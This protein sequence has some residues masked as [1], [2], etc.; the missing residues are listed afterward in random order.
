MVIAT[1]MDFTCPYCRSLVPV[2]DSVLSAFPADVAVDF[3]HFPLDSHEFAVPG[4]VA[5]ECA[6]R[7]GRFGHMYH[8]LY[9]QMESIGMKQWREFAADAGIPDVAAF[10]RCI[11]LPV[12]SFLRIGAGRAL[13]ES[14]G[15]VGTPTIWVN[16][17]QHSG[18]SVEA[19]R[20][21][22]DKLGIP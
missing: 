14:I 11:Q 10:E 5:A 19:F 12:D 20:A 15:V 13:G 22:A 17:R 21:R 2:L 1:F 6:H 4:A 7:Q 16:G 8:V 18:R 9:D 3:H